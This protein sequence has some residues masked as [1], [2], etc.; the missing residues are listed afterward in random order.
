M[1]ENRV[2]FAPYLFRMTRV[3]KPYV[4]VLIGLIL[5]MALF[6][7]PVTVSADAE[8]AD[9][10]SDLDAAARESSNPLGGDFMI[11]L[12]KIDNYFMEGNITSSLR[13]VN[14]W[15]FQP[16]V[17]VDGC[18]VQIQR[19]LLV[20][21]NA[22]T[23]MLVLAVRLFVEVFVEAHRITEATTSAAGNA[24]SQEHLIFQFLLVTNTLNLCS[25]LFGQLDRHGPSL[26][27]FTCRAARRGAGL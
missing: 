12:N 3:I 26:R 16:V 13:N 11:L 24:D 1:K 10:F 22:D 4:F 5:G 18:A 19:A 21:H 6:L 17:P 25:S 9:V 7:C 20:N 8:E 2:R 15:S 23:E 27:Q 14:V